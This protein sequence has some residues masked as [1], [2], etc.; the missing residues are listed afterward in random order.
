MKKLYRKETWVLI[1]LMLNGMLAF[2]GLSNETESDKVSNRNS[3]FVLECTGDVILST[4]AEVDAFPAVN[5]CTEIIGRLTISGADITN[6]DSLSSLFKVT[7]NLDI[8]SNPRLA[9]IQGLNNLV[10]IAGSLFINNNDLLPNLNGL[11]SMTQLVGGDVSLDISDNASLIHLDALSALTT[12]RSGPLHAAYLR[13]TNNPKL[14]NVNGLQSLAL[15]AGSLFCGLEISNNDLLRGLDG[16][17]AL[18]TLWG[19]NLFLAIRDNASLTNVNGLSSLTLLSQRP[20]VDVTNNPSLLQCCGLYKI[21]EHSYQNPGGSTGELVDVSG[22]G[23]ACTEQEILARGS[24]CNGGTQPQD[25]YVTTEYHSGYA[26]HATNIIVLSFEPGILYELRKNADDSH[27][28]G[29]VPGNIGLF[30]GGVTETTEYNVLALNPETGCERVLSAHP[31]ITILALSDSTE[32]TRIHL[33]EKDLVAEFDTLSVGGGTNILILNGDAGVEYLLRSHPDNTELAGPYPSTVGL[34]SG[35]LSETTIFNV[36][37]IDLTTNCRQQ[38]TELVTVSVVND[39]IFSISDNSLVVY[40][41][42]GNGEFDVELKSNST[43]TN[44]VTVTV[45][46]LLGAQLTRQTLISENQ[47]LKGHVDMKPAKAGL[48]FLTIQNS[49]GARLTRRIVIRDY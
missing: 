1:V 40:P 3:I 15:I 45:T 9:S 11:E 49:D 6:L 22:N 14:A 31:I 42:P 5:G 30:A 35:S 8:S 46:D 24:C 29:P 16:L 38:M 23:A 26:P 44:Y 39:P 21:V 28:A 37:A 43:D 4:Q 12:I 27:V 48:Y 25:K 2:G 10:S 20:R 47:L 19:F 7:G 18:D 33:A 13:I 36:V 17:A 41:N 34:Y 32:C